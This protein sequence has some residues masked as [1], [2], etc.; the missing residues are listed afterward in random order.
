MLVGNKTAIMKFETATKFRLLQVDSFTQWFGNEWVQV[1]DKMMT[2]GKYWLGHTERRQFEGIEFEPAG[3]RKGYYNL[4][5]GFA[6][7]PRKGDC[8]KFL[9][10]I[11]DNVAQGDE[12]IYNWIVGWWAQIFQQPALKMETALVLRGG[13][14]AGKTKIGKVFGSLL[15][16]HYLL[17]SSP[18][19]ITGQFNSHMKSLLVLHA[20]EAFWAGDKKA[21]GTL[22]DLVSGDTHM[23]E[24]KGVDPISDQELHPAVRHRQP[25]LD[26]PGRVQ[27]SALG[28]VRHRRGPACRTTP[29][30]PPSTRR[31]TT[32]AAR[33]CSIICC[34][35][36]PHEGQP[37]GGPEDRGAAAISKS[38]A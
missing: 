5:Q 2:A 17:V 13:F 20:D 38:R 6:V 19:Y 9:A 7:Q 18:R 26:D 10:H 27:G 12:E 36:R 15:D 23:L 28:S 22:K 25:R 8:S 14:G 30:S 3:G 11:R 16:E 31:W 32:A 33:H 21:E 35:G 1:G 29:T 24:H 37:A 4:Y 34:R